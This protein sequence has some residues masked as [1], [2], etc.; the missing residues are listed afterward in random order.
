MRRR[1]LSVRRKTSNRT[2]PLRLTAM[3]DILTCLLLFL[4]K[5]FAVESPMTPVPGITLPSSTSEEHP[6]ESFVVA[7]SGPSILVEGVA[8]ASVAEVIGS[9]DVF[10]APLGQRLAEIRAQK[11]EIARLRGVTEIDLGQVTV[12]GDRLIEYRLLERVIYT[13]GQEGFS[14]I[15][16]AVIR[17][18]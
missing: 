14:E 11:E 17:E 1:T 5:C 4:V 10:I 15:S 16:L 2:P 8:V 12:Q 18:A 9:P 6:E 7:I 3:V 13:L